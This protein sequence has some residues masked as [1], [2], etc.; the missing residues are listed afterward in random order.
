MTRNIGESLGVGA[1][2]NLT[3]PELGLYDST[4]NVP[5]LALAGNLPGRGEPV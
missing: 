5:G 3:N 2:V 4:V 1:V